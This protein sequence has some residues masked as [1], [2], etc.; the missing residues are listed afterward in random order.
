MQPRMGQELAV[1]ASMMA[2]WWHQPDGLVAVHSDEGSQFSGRDW[3]DFLK[4]H[5]RLGSM[6][7]RGNCHDNAVAESLYRLFK[8]KRIQLGGC[9]DREEARWDG[10][11]YIE[12]FGNV[13]RR[14]G[15]SSGLPPK[16]FKER[17]VTRLAS[18]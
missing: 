6:S 5:C 13:R 16:E 18:V 3:Q 7:R 4:A 1:I 8:R 15:Y 10:V 2:G 14:H 9:P 11:N 17:I 12:H